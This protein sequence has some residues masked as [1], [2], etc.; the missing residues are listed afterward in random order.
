[1][2]L[3]ANFSSSES[4]PSPNLVT[5][6]DTS[7]GTDLTITTRH[8]YI[9]LADGTYLVQA[10]TTTNYEIWDYVNLSITLNILT[11]SQAANVTVIWLNGSTP[12]YTKTILMEWNLY[13]YLFLFGLLS[14]QTSNPSIIADTN[15]Y[16]NFLKMIVN[17]FNA[18]KAIELMDDIYSGQGALDRNQFLIQNQSLF[19]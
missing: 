1:M 9:Q 7:V 10:G 17:L 14:T 11:Q 6:L 2:P 12:V 3:T 8:I 13:D 4:L 18:E 5:F 15:Y 16:D 19:F